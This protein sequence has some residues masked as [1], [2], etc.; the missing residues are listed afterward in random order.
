MGSMSERASELLEAQ[1][2]ELLTPQ[3]AA[4]MLGLQNVQQAARLA[5]KGE[6]ECERTKGGHR[7]YKLSSVHEFAEKIE[8]V[9]PGTCLRSH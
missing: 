1:K 2:D 8:D 4:L 7:R 5:D 9:P 6:L 3:Q